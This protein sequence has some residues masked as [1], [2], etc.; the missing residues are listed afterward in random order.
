VMSALNSEPN[1]SFC[2]RMV[3]P[4][5]NSLSPSST[6][7]DRCLGFACFFISLDIMKSASG[8]HFLGQVPRLPIVINEPQQRPVSVTRG[9]A[10]FRASHERLVAPSKFQLHPTGA[11]PMNG[12]P[13][14][15]GEPQF[16]QAPNHDEPRAFVP[17]SGRSL[18]FTLADFC[19]RC[20]RSRGPHADG[21][22]SENKRRGLCV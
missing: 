2:A 17:V 5:G 3:D 12:R 16:C 21:V 1:Y 4:Q 20:V 9:W 10:R 11:S 14:L 13:S 15:F 19:T 6:T 22:C 8:V 7:W 18:T